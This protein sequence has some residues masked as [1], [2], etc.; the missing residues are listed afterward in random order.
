MSDQMYK[1]YIGIDVSK[2]KLDVAISDDDCLQVE[3]S[4]IGFKELI[5]KLPNKK[6][7]LITLEASGGYEKLVA[8][9]LRHKK[10][11][12]AVVNAKRVRDF[13]KASGKLAKT[14]HIDA[15]AIRAFAKAF[16]PKPQ[17]L[18]TPIEEERVDALNR[19]GQLIKM[20]TTE[21]N[22]LEQ[23]SKNYHRSIKK[24]IQFLEE[25]V[26]KI[27]RSLEEKISEDTELKERVEKLDAIKGVGK[28]TAMNVLL[29][30][31]ELG[32][33]SAKEASAL[34]GVAPY[35]HDSGQ[36]KGKRQIRGGRAPVRT[37][38]YMAILSARKFNPAIKK[39][40]DR[41]IQKGKLKKVA[42]VACMRKLI[43]I[44]NAMMRDGSEW[45]PSMN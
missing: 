15:N 34:A 22:H 20:I 7:T 17:S 40:Y 23:A 6:R 44:M 39:F 41:L 19:R 11:D 21:K 5:K 16:N 14:D 42:M 3:N 33:L 12:V 32:Q 2:H 29:H 10:F 1:F 8:N 35:N 43:I 18:T 36:M 4:E 27:D 37:A 38:L 13:A 28:I 24:H 26:A 30:M 9:Y 45:K 25:E 31:P